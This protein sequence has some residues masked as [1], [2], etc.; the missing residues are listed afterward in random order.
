MEKHNTG[1]NIALLGRFFA[2]RVCYTCCDK[3][4]GY[5]LKAAINV[6]LSVWTNG[7]PMYKLLPHLPKLYSQLKERRSLCRL[8]NGYSAKVLHSRN[9]MNL[10]V[11]G[12]Y[13]EGKLKRDPEREEQYRRKLEAQNPRIIEK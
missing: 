10:T 1:P 12:M 13:L 5:L 11:W 4:E 7:I 6:I 2:Q 8:I 3:K 9:R